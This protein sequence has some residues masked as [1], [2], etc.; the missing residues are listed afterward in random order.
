MMIGWCNIPTCE[1][2]DAQSNI[3]LTF[4]SLCQYCFNGMNDCTVLDLT[5]DDNWQPIALYVKP[6]N[7]RNFFKCAFIR[8]YFSIFISN[9]LYSVGL[10]VRMSFH[11]ALLQNK[12]YINNTNTHNGCISYISNN[13]IK[14]K[15]RQVLTS[16]RYEKLNKIIRNGVVL[17]NINGQALYTRSVSTQKK[18]LA[19]KVSNYIKVCNYVWNHTAL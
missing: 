8:Y 15:W 17:Y 7:F 6:S 5:F 10:L 14:V 11:S 19:P 4:E 16:N 1:W 18:S 12:M 9:I 13:H 3:R 2:D